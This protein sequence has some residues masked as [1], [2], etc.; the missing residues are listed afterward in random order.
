MRAAGGGGK[1]WD[2]ERLAFAG[3]DQFGD[4]FTEVWLLDLFEPSSA[5]LRRVV[6]GIGRGTDERAR[7]L[8]VA[9]VDPVHGDDLVDDAGQLTAGLRA[10]HLQRE[11]RRD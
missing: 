2:G 8:A 4:Q 11:F 1:R 9:E 3:T 10:L 5:I 7:R 6:P